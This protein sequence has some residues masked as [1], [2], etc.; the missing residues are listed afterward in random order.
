MAKCKLT[1]SIGGKA[2]E[3]S[4]AGASAIYYANWY[5]PVEGETAVANAIAYSTDTDGKIDKITLPTGEKFYKI[6]GADN[7][8]SFSDVL[9]AGGNGGKYRQHTVNAVV[10][11]L[12]S[13][14]E[15]DALSLGKF[16]AIGFTKA[17]DIKL[18]GRTSGLSAPAGGTDYNSGAAE[19]DA[20][21]WTLIHQ[22]V[23]TE[24]APNVKD[25][26]VIASQIQ[27]EEIIP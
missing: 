13:S 7:T 3:Y 17:G 27:V 10:N 19:A 15:T 23:S 8:L 26:A 4:V 24:T 25:M 21:G 20:T 22:G 18:L 1:T 16:I 6:D 14:D 5:P 12:E 11:D 2:C 9:L